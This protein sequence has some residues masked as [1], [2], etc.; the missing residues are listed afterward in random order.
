M[1]VL[2]GWSADHVMEREGIKETRS[3]REVL[4]DLSDQKYDAIIYWWENI[5]KL[6]AGEMNHSHGWWNE[7]E[8]IKETVREVVQNLSEIWCCNILMR[9]FAKSY[10]REKWTIYSHGWWNGINME[11]I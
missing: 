6:W 1:S 7:G 2:V 10:E 3:V 8:G 11:E 5:Q 4:K 9:K